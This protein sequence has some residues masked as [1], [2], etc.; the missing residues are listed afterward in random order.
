MDEGESDPVVSLRTWL[1]STGSGGAGQYER[2]IEAAFPDDH[3]IRTRDQDD[4]VHWRRELPGEGLVIIVGG[5]GAWREALQS[6]PKRVTP[7]LLPAGSLSQAGVELGQDASVDAWRHWRRT[8]IQLGQIDGHGSAD[9]GHAAFFLMAGAGV[10]AD[11][12][13]R[14]RPWLKRR[15]GK[16]AY[17]QALIERLLKPV[18]KRIVVGMDGRHFRTSQVLVHNGSHYGGRY[19]VAATD[20]FT[21]GYRVLIWKYPGRCMWCLTMM[22]L[23]FGLPSAW[24]VHEAS[25]KHVRIRGVG[26]MRCQIDGD[27]GPALPLRIR[28]TSARGIAITGT[29]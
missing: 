24:L 21:P 20:V 2:R 16:W 18:H 5:D 23:M 9:S 29:R 10:E 8:D 27:V 12:V 13:A 7:G 26:R 22:C 19:R 15:I 6:A 1:M 3:L 17:V 14:V 25:A 4:I 11:A 28:P